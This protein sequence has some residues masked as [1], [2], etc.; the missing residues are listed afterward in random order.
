MK[1]LIFSTL[2]LLTCAFPGRLPR[3]GE[4]NHRR[5]SQVSSN[6]QAPIHRTQHSG[7]ENDATLSTD[8]VKRT[9]YSMQ[10]RRQGRFA[11]QEDELLHNERRLRETHP[12]SRISSVTPTVNVVNSMNHR[13]PNAMPGHSRF[14]TRG[15]IHEA[16]S[17]AWIKRKSDESPETENEATQ[18]TTV[19]SSEEL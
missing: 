16:L 6:G 9:V 10:Q 11:S 3:F 15:R 18:E 19:L 13:P 4:A 17:K 1:L 5:S 8:N 14:P 12:H 7:L 2:L